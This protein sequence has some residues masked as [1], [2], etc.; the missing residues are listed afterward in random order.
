MFDINPLDTRPGEAELLAAGAAYFA[1]RLLSRRHRRQI[2]IAINITT[3]PMRVPIPRSMLS[4]NDS[5]FRRQLPK[6]FAFSVSVASGMRSAME[7]IAHEIIHIAQVLYRRLIITWRILPQRSI[8]RVVYQARWENGR[9]MPMGQLEWAA[10]PWEIEASRWQSIL[11]D[12]FLAYSTGQLHSLPI[13]RPR[14][15]QLALFDIGRDATPPPRVNAI[16][17]LARISHMPP[18]ASGPSMSKAS[19]TGQNDTLGETMSLP[20][21][22]IRVDVSGLSAPRELTLDAIRQ[23]RQELGSRGLIR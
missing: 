11:V 9:A 10:R 7:L 12:E 14:R 16:S 15:R 19:Q 13:Q 4:T 21:P 17:S 2:E 22:R 3:Q 18:F 6:N 5:V 20:S 8:D 1:N 23:K